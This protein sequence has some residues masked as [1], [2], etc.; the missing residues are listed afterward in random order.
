M[1]MNA[2]QIRAVLKELEA[3][4]R[5]NDRVQTDRSLKMLNLERE[6]AQLVRAT[7]P[8]EKGVRYAFFRGH[9]IVPKEK[10][11]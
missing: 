4:G 10:G 1:V 2:P 8:E 7:C 11:T 5:E 9:R 6:T 3:W